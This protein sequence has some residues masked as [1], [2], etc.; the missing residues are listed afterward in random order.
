MASLEQKREAFRKYLES[1]GAIDCLS[2]AL[3][4]LYQEDQKPDDAC[5][6]IRQTMCESCPTDEQVA[7]MI[8]DLDKAKQDNCCLQ[9]E[10]TKMKGELRRSSSEIALALEDGFK[11]LEEDGDCKSLLKT[12]L[13][14]ELF[15]GL[16]GERTALKSTLLDCIQSGL[17]NHDSGVGLYAADA[18]CYEVFA[19]LFNAVIQDYH[20]IAD[21]IQHPA[22]NWGD[23]STFENLD[24]DGDFII[25]TRVRCGR[26][27]QGF[28]FNPCLKMDQYEELMSRIKTV[29]EGLEAEDLKGE[30]HPLE[31]MSKEHMIQLIDEHYLFKEGDRFLH[32]AGACRFW[33]IGRAIFYNEPKTFV[34]WIN[35][36]DHMRVI[37]MDKGGDLGAIYQRLVSAVEAIGKDI[38]FERSDRLGYLT[39]C[40]TNLGTTIRASVHIKLPNLGSKREKLEEEAAK[41]N[42]QVRGTR[43]EHTDSEEGVFDVSNKRRLGLTEFEAV[44]EMYNGIKQLIELEKATEAGTELNG[45]VAEAEPAEAEPAEAPA[46]EAA[47]A[48]SE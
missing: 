3:I 33:P 30:F 6:F 18:E 13:T 40:P 45:I 22:S 14:R 11:A 38:A 42:L 4:K 1:A 5:K 12:H 20:G 15:E 7:Q 37:S 10:L 31:G 47:P 16:K 2:K 27:I 35:E 46:E 17:E 44:E 48:A 26:S 34:V 8:E 36:E 43:G 9:R 19:P 32:S 23:A 39:F 41:L 25:S 28:P 29:L 24:P 21:D